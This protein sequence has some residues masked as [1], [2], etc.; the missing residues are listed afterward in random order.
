M[1][2]TSEGRLVQPTIASR[3]PQNHLPPRPSSGN[4]LAFYCTLCNFLLSRSVIIKKSLRVRVSIMKVSGNG[5]QMTASD[6]VKL[7]LSHFSPTGRSHYGNEHSNVSIKISLAQDLASDTCQE[8]IPTQNV[9]ENYRS[10]QGLPEIIL[11]KH[12]L[13]S[14]ST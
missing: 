3:A 2:G 11:S 8:E 4:C 9:S 5:L 7:P 1:E 6:A 12:P 14:R 10:L 13:Q